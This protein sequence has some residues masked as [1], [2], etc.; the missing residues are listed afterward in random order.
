MSPDSGKIFPGGGGNSGVWEPIIWV[1]L[2]KRSRKSMENTK[3]N[4]TTNNKLPTIK[5]LDSLC[6]MAYINVTLLKINHN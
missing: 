1:N 4:K 2:L 5:I 3:Q 6:R